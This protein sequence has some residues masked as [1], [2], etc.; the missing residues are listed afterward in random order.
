M[1]YD[2]VLNCY[3]AAVARI[4]LS[5]PTNYAPYTS[6]YSPLLLPPT[7]PTPYTSYYTPYY[8]PYRAIA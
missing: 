3:R 2:Q 6:S 5:G 8:P 1:N 4:K 7:T